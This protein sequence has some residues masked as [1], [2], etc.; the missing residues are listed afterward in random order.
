MGSLLSVSNGDRVEAGRD[1]DV[2][3]VGGLSK[4]IV[5]LD[6]EAGSEVWKA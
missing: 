1:V 5:A 3:D 2:E 4:Q 6:V